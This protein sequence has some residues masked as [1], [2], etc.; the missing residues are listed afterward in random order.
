MVKNVRLSKKRYRRNVGKRTRVSKKSYRKRRS[1]KSV[2]K[3]I[4]YGGRL[5]QEQIQSLK[6][7]RLNNLKIIP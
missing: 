7:F 6:K 5:T 2:K 1:N 4:H 3:R